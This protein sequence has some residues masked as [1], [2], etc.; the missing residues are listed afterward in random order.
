L[1]DLLPPQLSGA[2][3]NFRN[4]SSLFFALDEGQAIKGVYDHDSSAGRTGE[5]YTE[6]NRLWQE[7]LQLYLSEELLYKES[8]RFVFSIECDLNFSMVQTQ[9][10]P[11][12]AEKMFTFLPNDIEVQ[13]S[14]GNPVSPWLKIAAG[15]FPFKYNPD[16]KNLGEFLLRSTAYPTVI[17]TEFEFPMTRELGLHLSGSFDWLFKNPAVDKLTWD[18]MLTSET[19]DYPLMDG[20]LTALLAN[21]F[22]HFVDIG[23]GVSFQRLFPVDESK[24]TPKNLPASQYL[25][26]NGTPSFYSYSSTK[27]MGRAS[28]ALLRFVPEFSMPPSFIFGKKPFFGREDLKVYGEAAVLGTKDYPAYDSFLKDTVYDTINGI[29]LPTEVP[30][31]GTGKPA[32]D[33]INY[34][35]KIM[36]RIPLM[37]GINLPTNPIISYGILPFILTKWLKDETGS[38]VRPLAWVTLVPALASG[39]L[40][41]FLG[42]D[43][44]L[45]E[46]SMEFEWHSQRFPN[47]NQF[48]INPDA[49]NPGKVPI[50]FPNYYRMESGFGNPEPS[51]YSLH[52]KK[53]FMQKFAVSGIVGRDHMR[54]ISFVPPTLD[55]TDD[56]LQAKDQWWWSVRLSANF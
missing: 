37:L 5:P 45:D 18:V 25:D 55:Q 53:S 43:I 7:Q 9:F 22:F 49:S 17:R 44:G 3:R 30:R 28:L 11:S 48:A 41:Q 20:T 4:K 21:D 51:K 16:A 14:L 47:S 32:P 50:P 29:P 19:H 1:S 38:D 13:Y 35:N 33:S 52:F 6:F 8:L 36:D 23:A 42:W 2:D 54:P 40:D 10:Y 39:V 27:L 26:I 15:Y 34:Y 56:F 46:L 24:T 31:P 12:T